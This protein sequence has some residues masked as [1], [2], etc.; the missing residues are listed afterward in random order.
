MHNLL[1]APLKVFRDVIFHSESLFRLSLR[2]RLGAVSP[3][4]SPEPRPE[5]MV[6]QTKSEWEEAFDEVK[7]LKLPPHV[8]PP[9]N[10]DS[11][12]ALSCI[13]KRTGRDA[14]VLDAGGEKYS[15]ILPWLYLYGYRNLWCV[16]FAFKRSACWGPIRFEPGDITCT[17]F[18][19]ESVDVITCLSVIE[20][21]VPLQAFFRE[22]SRILK[23]GGLLI[24]STD[25]YPLPIDTD[26]A[27]AFDA[28]IRIF[29]A[30]EVRSAV[31][32]AGKC[33]LHPTTQIALECTEKP[34][35]WKEYSL[36]FSY[37]LVTLQKVKSL[38]GVVVRERSDRNTD[39]R[40]F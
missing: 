11:L 13:L 6:L 7:R 5:N 32:M 3:A 37:L 28:P 4:G 23:P 29:T 16:N 10:W 27:R 21:G 14:A 15:Q 12:A 2:L 25:Y 19:P 22:A 40:V 20:H 9:K 39:G 30:D 17:R 24:V 38:D 31:E 1:K 8:G 33:G 35:R 18:G 26:G 36:D 34:V